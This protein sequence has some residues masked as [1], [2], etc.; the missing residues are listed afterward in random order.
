MWRVV[1]RGPCLGPWT[2]WPPVFIHS[3]C[4]CYHPPSV[5]NL[6]IKC[7]A[8][9]KELA[10]KISQGCPDNLKC[11]HTR[12]LC[13][14]CIPKM[15]GVSS[16]LIKLIIQHKFYSDICIKITHNISRLS[17]ASNHYHLLTWI[18]AYCCETKVFWLIRDLNWNL[19]LSQLECIQFR[20]LASWDTA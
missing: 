9:G 2:M 4:I 7:E 14:I 17:R 20:P 5:R 15:I 1:N 16:I 12:L 13:V 3:C 8:H 10:K 6:I 19:C 11:L 18:A